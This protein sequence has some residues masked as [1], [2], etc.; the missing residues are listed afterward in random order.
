MDAT[1]PTAKVTEDVYDEWVQ[2][3]SEYDPDTAARAF[4][5]LRE[6]CKWRPSMADFRS[7]YFLVLAL[8]D[9]AR[10]QLPAG[11]GGHDRESLRDIYGSSVDAWLY[12]WR[13]DMAISLDDLEYRRAF[14]ESRGLHHRSCPRRGS[15]PQIPAAAKAARDKAFADRR[16]SIGPNVDPVAYVEV[17]PKSRRQR[18]NVDEVKRIAAEAVEKLDKR[19]AEEAT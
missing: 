19:R 17:P 11:D 1:W 4:R 10:K 6:T 15:A 5:S 13:C 9:E 3:L 16:I 14:D 2:Y 8:A 7:A 12:C 18:Q